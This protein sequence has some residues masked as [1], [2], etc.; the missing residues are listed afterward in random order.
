[1][2]CCAR[3]QALPPCL[4]KLLVL[5]ATL[6]QGAAWQGACCHVPASLLPP[7]PLLLLLLMEV[8]CSGEALL[9]LPRLHHLGPD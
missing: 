8:A 7:P 9:A 1:V 2:R 4:L 5:Q 3:P 6:L